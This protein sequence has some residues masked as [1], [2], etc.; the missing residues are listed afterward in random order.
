[1]SGGRV[2]EALRKL[3]DV[4][5]FNHIRQEV[6]AQERHAKRGVKRRKL[7]SMRWRRLFASEVHPCTPCLWDILINLLCN[8]CGKEWILLR[9]LAA[10]LGDSQLEIM[11]KI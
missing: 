11:D 7:K 4:V 5:K 1:M 10:E 9:K 3:G 2:N 6:R 8:R